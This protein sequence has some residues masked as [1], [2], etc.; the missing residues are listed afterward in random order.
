MAYYHGLLYQPSCGACPLQRDKKVLP[1]GPIPAKLVFVGEGPGTAE[2]FEGRGFVGASGGLL[3]QLCQAYGFGRDQVFVTNSQL[4]KKRDVK[5]SSGATLREAQVAMMAA[6]CCRKRL[7]YELMVVTQ[8]DP[9]AVIVPLGNI[10]LQMLTKRRNAR[11]FAYRGT[12]QRI[13]LQA[14]W[15]EL[16]TAA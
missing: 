14:L 9:G 10:A 11:V 13:D 7:V 8:C 1:D 5:L 15:S 6:Q 4:C 3:W 16:N 12:I 2:V